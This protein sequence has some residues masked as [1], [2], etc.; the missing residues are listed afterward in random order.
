MTRKAYPA[1][2]RLISTTLYKPIADISKLS[3]QVGRISV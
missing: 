1:S 3:G 2:G